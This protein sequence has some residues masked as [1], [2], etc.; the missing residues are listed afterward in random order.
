VTLP[1]A[2]DNQA[3]RLSKRTHHVALESL[4]A[5]HITSITLVL[6]MFAI[7]GYVGG[8]EDGHKILAPLLLQFP[9]GWN[10]GTFLVTSQAVFFGSRVVATVLTLIIR[11]RYI[12]LFCAVGCFVFTILT[13]KAQG[14]T[15]IIAYLLG[16]AFMA[17]LFP[18]LFS[19]AMH[20]MGKRTALGGVLLAT[21]TC[22]G[23][24]FPSIQE[25]VYRG[26][27]TLVHSIYVTV[28]AFGCVLVTA[29]Y[30]N[31]YPLVRQQV[32]VDTS[33][34]N[35]NITEDASSLDGNIDFITSAIND[36][37]GLQPRR[38]SIIGYLPRK[39]SDAFSFL[40]RSKTAD[41]GVSMELRAQEGV[42]RSRSRI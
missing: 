21:A 31:L 13:A 33:E 16:R 11:P 10:I 32:D 8:Q 3:E 7:F 20:A 37:E 38:K 35:S 19:Q 42:R 22:G 12:I 41:S 5:K 36:G 39:F 23:G 25:N 29:L 28:A 9:I 1:E 40:A 2:T 18:L 26:E 4:R 14:N 17:P 30:L 34:V 6:A 24:V 15:V 27:T